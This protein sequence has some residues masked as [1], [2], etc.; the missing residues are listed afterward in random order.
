MNVKQILVENPRRIVLL[1]FLCILIAGV[2]LCNDYGKPWDENGEIEITATNVKK[3]AEIFHLQGTDFYQWIEE[4]SNGHEIETYSEKDHGEAPYYLAMPFLYMVSDSPQMMMNIWHFY[5]FLIFVA[6]LAA[7]YFLL[8]FLTGSWKAG[9]LGCVFMLISPRIFAEA[10]YNNKDIVL[11]SFVLLTSAFALKAIKSEDF[12]YGIGFGVC[13][14]FTSNIKIMGFWLA[15]LAGILYLFALIRTGDKKKL[16]MC[17]AVSVLTYVIGFFLLTPATWN[18]IGGYFSYVIQATVG[19]DRWP[20]YV[21]YNG[22]IYNPSY[23]SLPWYYLVYMIVVTTP[24]LIVISAG[25]GAVFLVVMTIKNRSFRSKQAKAYWMLAVFAAVPVVYTMLGNPTIYNGWRHFYFIYGVVVILA[26]FGIRQ[27]W[28]KKIGKQ[29]CLFLIILQ[30]CMSVVGM[31]RNHPNEF[32]YYNILAGKNAGERLE[33]DYWNLSTIECLQKLSDEKYNGSPIK[34]TASEGNTDDGLR[35]ALDVLTEDY[36]E[37]F[38]YVDYVEHQEEADYVL[39]NPTYQVINE[40]TWEL[41]KEGGEP[42]DMA[43]LDEVMSIEAYGNKIMSVY[44]WKN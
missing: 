26:V 27:V 2:F 32:S 36:R 20:G 44:Q 12:R 43:L 30:V 8:R 22:W 10:F 24:L 1:F 34:I 16:A 4:T 18:S 9:L 6:G 21:Y 13:A 40:Y 35:K 14:A 17:G 42:L 41:L 23:V 15:L 39:V 19:F 5:T 33:L 38:Q 28:Q 11:M 37:K 3:Y 29:I 25:V 7:L 31:V